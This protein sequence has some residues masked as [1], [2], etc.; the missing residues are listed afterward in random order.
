MWVQV[1]TRLLE[2]GWTSRPD[3]GTE[4]RVKGQAMG[5]SMVE[6]V[7]GRALV[8]SME[9]GAKRHAHAPARGEE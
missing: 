9:V 2:E 4:A 5:A 6:R 1:I 8:I 3:H 7:D